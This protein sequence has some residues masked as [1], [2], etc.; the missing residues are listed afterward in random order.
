[1]LSSGRVGVRVRYFALLVVLVT[2]PAC[3]SGSGSVH[4][5]GIDGFGAVSSAIWTVMPPVQLWF[6]ESSGELTDF[7]EVAFDELGLRNYAV[8]CAARQD[9]LARWG[10]LSEDVLDAEG[11][12]WCD[13]MTSLDAHLSTERSTFHYFGAYAGATGEL[14]ASGPVDDG[15]A[16]LSY[17]KDAGSACPTWD[18][19][20]CAFTGGDA[21]CGSED[22][23]WG[24]EPSAFEIASADEDEVV[25]S[26]EGELT[27]LDGGSDDGPAGTISVTFRAATCAVDGISSIVV[28]P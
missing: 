16:A 5:E 13:A 15:G 17:G 7:G 19:D 11:E 1:M 4:V 3:S 21:S 27:A 23:A 9:F 6:A 22:Q 25:G 24:V 12:A 2:T 10:E 20:A 8:S 28:T 14:P 18:A 26:L